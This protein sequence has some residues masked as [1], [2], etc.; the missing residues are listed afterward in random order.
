MIIFH[1]LLFTYSPELVVNTDDRRLER[2]S[3]G[4]KGDEGRLVLPLRDRRTLARR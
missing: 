2:V 3:S 1:D 4:R